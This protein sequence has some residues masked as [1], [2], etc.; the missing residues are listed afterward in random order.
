[1]SR[2]P[3]VR[4]IET[5]LRTLWFLL[6]EKLDNTLSFSY[7]SQIRILIGNPIHTLNPIRLPI[8]SR[9]ELAP[10]QKP[11]P[12]TDRRTAHGD[13]QTGPRTAG[14]GG[15]DEN[16]GGATPRLPAPHSRSEGEPL[17]QRRALQHAANRRMKLYIYIY[18][19]TCVL[20]SRALT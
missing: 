16:A 1:M 9:S 8:T 3:R 2:N 13:W 7:Q 12:S 19:V 15:Q 11:N 18:S 20:V 5:N 4:N 10:T 6:L 17:R 14:D